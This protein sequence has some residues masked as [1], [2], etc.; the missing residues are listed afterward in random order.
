[1]LKG[2]V[3]DD[4]TAHLRGTLTELGSTRF[5][6]ADVLKSPELM[7][8]RRE[9]GRVVTELFAD[10]GLDLR[11][12]ETVQNQY[13]SDLHR[14]AEERRLDAV[15][16]SAA[17]RDIL[18]KRLDAKRRLVDTGGILVPPGTRVS[19]RRPFTLDKPFLIVPS[20]AFISGDQVAPFDS[21]AKFDFTRTQTSEDIVRFYYMWENPTDAAV[22]IDVNTSVGFCGFC[23]T[24]AEGSFYNS[25]ETR[26]WIFCALTVWPWSHQP[27]NTL[28]DLEDVLR[29]SATSNSVFDG[30][31]G[32]PVNLTQDLRSSTH[33]W[34]SISP[35]ELVVFEVAVVVESYVEESGNTSVD[36]SDGGFHI[37]SPFLSVGMWP[38]S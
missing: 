2:E 14:V 11:R 21:W 35:R 18:H 10:A 22:Q 7:K 9:A 24:H 17:S 25:T 38:A 8:R 15:S 20:S 5:E 3:M 36:F 12:L 16:K 31:S 33:S 19:E 37:A 30:D 13:R 23:K 34:L 26:L 27:A 6:P 1:M 29:I 28:A 4:S 32:G